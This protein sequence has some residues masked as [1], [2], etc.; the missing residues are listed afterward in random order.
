MTDQNEESEYRQHIRA[1]LA[2]LSAENR[3]RRQL[4]SLLLKVAN[5][6]AET[7]AQQ[8]GTRL[9][10]PHMPYRKRLWLRLLWRLWFWI[11]YN[12]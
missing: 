4:E 8:L 7:L 10:P 1:R 2:Q 5:R 12:P 11:T 3:E 9:N 6:H